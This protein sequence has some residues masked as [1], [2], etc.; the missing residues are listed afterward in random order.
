MDKKTVTE[1][2]ME[3]YEKTVARRFRAT[4]E[5]IN[6]RGDDVHQVRAHD[7]AQALQLRLHGYP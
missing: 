6:D 3:D 4:V 7:H 1:N 2:D 5:K